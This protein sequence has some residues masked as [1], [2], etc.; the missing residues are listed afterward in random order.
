M[1]A[2]PTRDALGDEILK[3]GLENDDIY[4]ID[5]DVA[6][7]CKTLEFAEKLPKQHVNVGISSRMRLAWQQVLPP[8]VRFLSL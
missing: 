3:L 5:C 1:N 2:K 8:P 6:K 7:S 4:V